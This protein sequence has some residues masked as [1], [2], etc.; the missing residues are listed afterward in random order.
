MSEL[1]KKLNP[2]SSMEILTLNRLLERKPDGL[3]TVIGFEYRDGKYGRSPVFKAAEGFKF[4]GGGKLLKEQLVPM[5][6]KE[7][8]SAEAIDE[9]FSKNPQAWK[10]GAVITLRNGNRFRPIEF[11]GDRVPETEDDGD[12][13]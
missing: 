6:E 7:Y 10:I 3:V 8:G 12:E 9:A 13:V 4:W 5:L 2:L 1:S 11:L